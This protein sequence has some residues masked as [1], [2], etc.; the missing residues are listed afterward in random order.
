MKLYALKG[1]RLLS[2]ITD[3]QY[4]IVFLEDNLSEEETLILLA[5]GEGHIYSE[6]FGETIVAGKNIKDE[7]EANEFAHYLLQP[8]IFQGL[9][10][11]A[12]RKRLYIRKK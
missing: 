8:S 6:H 10:R 11:N 7:Y 1:I 9:I 5:H 3:D 2:T 12:C 4:R